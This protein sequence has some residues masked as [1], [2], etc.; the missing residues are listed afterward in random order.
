[1]RTTSGRAREDPCP[2][3]SAGSR[4]AARV[5]GE[6]NLGSSG[7]TLTAMTWRAA[8]VGQRRGAAGAGRCEPASSRP[9]GR[10]RRSPCAGG[11]RSCDRGARGDADV[12]GSDSAGRRVSSDRTAASAG[13]GRQPTR[14]VASVGSVEYD[15]SP[16]TSLVRVHVPPTTRPDANAAVGVEHRADAATAGS[17]VV[18]RARRPV[19]LHQG[20][21]RAPRSRVRGR[22]SGRRTR[23]SVAGDAGRPRRI[24]GVAGTADVVPRA[25]SASTGG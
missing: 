24:E 11:L 25:C 8:L 5:G 10:Q 19:E 23:R 6:V 2:R 4:A 14:L 20:P 16:R 15:F 21:R 12:A 7:E 3:V 22:P 9:R 13:A 1:M 18:L 17:K